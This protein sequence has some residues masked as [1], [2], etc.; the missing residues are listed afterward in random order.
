MDRR[1]PE[2]VL[3]LEG[4][5]LGAS[6]DFQE[7]VDRLGQ[8]VAF[9]SIEDITIR[10]SGGG[11]R[12]AEVVGGR[13]LREF[14]SVQMLSYPR[15]AAALLNV[16][17]DYLRVHG[18]QGVNVGG[19]DVPTKLYKYVRLANRGVPVPA[20]VY[21]PQHHLVAAF[22]ELVELFD[23]PFVLK[24]VSGGCGTSRTVI[25]DRVVFDDAVRH[26]AGRQV[27]LLAQE[28]VPASEQRRL[29][30]FGDRVGAAQELAEADP[31]D[32]LGRPRWDR[33]RP[34]RVDHL[35]EPQVGL[36]VAAAEAMDYG[37]ASVHLMKNWTTT[38]WQ[39]VDISATPLTGAGAGVEGIQET[40][41]L[42]L[43][44]AAQLA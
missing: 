17:A 31:T 15:G 16:V 37:L 30:V 14:A 40:Y 27:R 29:F 10:L 3:L 8:Q 41:A 4:G 1:G 34:L 39:V 5:E 20:T 43:G 33:S 42:F 9:R 19:L 32:P 18:V 13:D 26:A 22:P 7:R 2:P 24:S 35:P 11:V 6:A 21:L 38:Q 25:T 36:A 28:L 12:M 44:G 23:L